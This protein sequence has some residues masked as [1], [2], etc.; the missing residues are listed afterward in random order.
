MSRR[1]SASVLNPGPATRGDKSRAGH[2]SLAVKKFPDFEGE[3]F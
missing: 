3:H 2:K 1:P